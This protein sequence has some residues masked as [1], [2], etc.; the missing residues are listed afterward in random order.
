MADATPGD[1]LTEFHDPCFDVII[2]SGCCRRRHRCRRH[3][4]EIIDVGA[5]ELE[6]DRLLRVEVVIEAARKDAAGISS[7]LLERGFAVQPRR[8]ASPPYRG[9]QSAG[10]RQVPC[11]PDSGRT[12]GRGSFARGCSALWLGWARYRVT[13]LGL[14]RSLVEASRLST[15]TLVSCNDEEAPD[16]ACPIMPLSIDQGLEWVPPCGGWLGTP[17]NKG[18]VGPAVTC[19]SSFVT[20]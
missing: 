4:V 16:P 20:R 12:A 5:N 14:V 9:S 1:R 2:G 17:G 7:D 10:R 3:A 18:A 8:T 11:E 13:A 19:P 15:L 6:D